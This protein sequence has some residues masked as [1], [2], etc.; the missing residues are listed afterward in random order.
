M[1]QEHLTGINDRIESSE[2]TL[3]Q[4]P[5]SLAMD[6]SA[7]GSWD[8][9]VVPHVGGVPF[10]MAGQGQQAVVKTLLAMSRQAAAAR[11]V[12]IEEPDNHLSHTSLNWLLDRIESLATDEQQLFV[13][14]HSSFVL[15][16]LGLNGLG[17]VTSTGVVSFA[18]L[19]SDTIRFMQRQPGF[20]TLRMVTADKVVLVEGPSDEIMFER[21][22]KDANG[23]VRPIENGIDVIAMRGLTITH[24]LRLASFLGKRCAVLRDNDGT[25]PDDI[26]SD[27]EDSLVD[28]ER[29][30]FIGSVPCGSTLEPQIIKANS[31]DTIRRIL[32]TRS[33][34]TLLT[35]MTN[36]KTEAAM[37]LAESS[38]RIVPPPY[39][40]AAIGFIDGK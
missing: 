25:D 20:D 29:Q 26:I 32:G 7:R 17:L 11:V 12:M 33:D 35:W 40:T 18:D 24:G 23:G 15:N 39:F 10:G 27:L 3:N 2:S 14:T 31:E 6:Q 4:A 37:R 8:A 30:V 38:E 16:R 9:S 13:T 5:L 28:A 1:G 22:Y 19:P 21:F 34:A 36:N